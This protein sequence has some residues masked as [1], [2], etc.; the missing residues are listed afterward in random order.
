[1]F[2]GSRHASALA[3]ALEK[4]GVRKRYF[5]WARSTTVNRFPEVFR[6]WRRLGLDAVFLGFE[7]A[8]D[9]ELADISKHSSVRENERAH[10]ALR[11]MGI[12]VQAGFMVRPDFT[13]HDFERLKEYVRTMPPAQVTFTV[14]TPS[15][16]SPAWERDK[17]AF[18]ADPIGLHDCM[19][20]LT[21]SAMPLREFYSRF[22]D[23]VRLGP[24]KNPLRAPGT[25]L[26][27]WDIARIWWAG[28]TY[29]SSLCKAYRDYPKELW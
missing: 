1:M 14:F 6:V 20:P 16:R 25:R 13:A 26:R 5:S 29:S 17:D 21:P 3:E 19:H 7:A 10:A 27:P 23:L 8:S 2:L 4:R 24:R 9:E 28:E 15:P 22:S 12:A 11:E 18:V